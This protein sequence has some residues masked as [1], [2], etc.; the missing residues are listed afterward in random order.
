MLVGLLLTSAMPWGWRFVGLL[1]LVVHSRLSR[2]SRRYHGGD[3]QPPCRLR[4]LPSGWRV[5]L[6]DETQTFADLAGPVRDWGVLLCFCLQER[7]E[8]AEPGQS[9]RRW[10]LAL[11]RDQLSPDDW[12]RL[13]VSLVW[14]R[15]AN[16]RQRLSAKPVGVSTLSQG[17]SSRPG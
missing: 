1:F 16:P 9:P 10:H 5:S 11:W 6:P 2:S 8:D 7:P 15:H 3:R 17:A 12:R 4:Q 14:R 13:R